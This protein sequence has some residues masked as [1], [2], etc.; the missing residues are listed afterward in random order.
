MA[1]LFS[2][3]E[4]PCCFT[5]WMDYVCTMDYYSAIK[6][7]G[8]NATGSNLDGPRDDH[9]KWRCDFTYMWNLKYDTNEFYLQNR[10]RLRQ[11]EQTCGCCGGGKDWEFGDYRCKLLHLEW[12]NNFCIVQE[13]IFSVLWLTKMERNIYKKSLYVYSWVTFLYNRDWHNIVNQLYLN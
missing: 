9:T 10:N 3:G 6:K 4:P 11:R 12:I 1:P 8:N 7:E 5:W 13:T 2:F